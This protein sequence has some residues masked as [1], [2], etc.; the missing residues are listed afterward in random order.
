MRRE[1]ALTGAGQERTFK[2][3]IS[4]YEY[5]GDTVRIELDD[6]PV[7]LYSP[8]MLVF[9]KLRAICQQMPNYRD[10]ANPT[11][12]PRDF[13]DIETVMGRLK[14]DLFSAENLARL[15]EVFRAKEVPLELLDLIPDTREF[16]EGDWDRVRQS[17][18]EKVKPVAYYFEFTASLA[19]RLREA[20]REK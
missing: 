19:G 15:G 12:R 9:E 18:S 3:E 13:Y 17:V 5:C 14:P 16:H 11:P 7:E 8:A 10:R 1:A 20:L 6:I 4:K 2:V